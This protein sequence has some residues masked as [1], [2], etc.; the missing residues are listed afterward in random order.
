[1]KKFGVA[2]G[3]AIATA[4]AL[5]EGES[6]GFDPSSLMTSAQS[7]V[8]GIA[9]ALGAILVAAA[10]IYL[11]LLGWRKFREATNKV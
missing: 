6:G 4:A 10:A 3:S 2:V 11:A 7:T 5:A 1:M 8:T 9:T